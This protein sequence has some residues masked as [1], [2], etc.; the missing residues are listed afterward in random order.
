MTKIEKLEKMGG[1]RWIKGSMDRIYFSFSAEDL[2]DISAYGAEGISKTKA[3]EYDMYLSMS[4]VYFDVTKDEVVVTGQAPAWMVRK[5]T[6]HIESMLEEV[7]EE[8]VEEVVAPAKDSIKALLASHKGM[9]IWDLVDI[10]EITMT[11]A[12]EYEGDM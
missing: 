9:D 10:G 5:I 6:A 3:R 11:E 8:P 1:K 7:V 2:W 12:H 4:K